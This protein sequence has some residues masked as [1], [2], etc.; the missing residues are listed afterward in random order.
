[1]GVSLPGGGL[2]VKDNRYGQGKMSLDDKDSS[3]LGR[4]VAIHKYQDIG[5]EIP[6]YDKL[7]LNYC[8]ISTAADKDPPNRKCADT[9]GKAKLQDIGIIKENKV[10]PVSFA[11]LDTNTQ[12]VV[13][14]YSTLD[15]NVWYKVKV[16][17]KP[18]R[19]TDDFELQYD[20]AN[21]CARRI[22]ANYLTSSGQDEIQRPDPYGAA[23]PAIAGGI[24]GRM[25][26]NNPK[27]GKTSTG[28][29][30]KTKPPTGV[31]QISCFL[32]ATSDAGDNEIGG[33]AL[34]VQKIG[35]K[36]VKLQAKLKHGTNM[37]G[38]DYSFHFHEFGDLRRLTPANGDNR[39]V[40]KIYKDVLAIDTLKASAGENTRVEETFTLGQNVQSVEEY[41]GRSL[42]IHSGPDTS[43][44]T[45]SYG[46]CG[47]ANPESVQNYDT[48]PP[49]IYVTTPKGNG[50]VALGLSFTSLLAAFL[51]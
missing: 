15:K 48:T 7:C 50:A 4:A 1:M 25:N 51:W 9:S 40:G 12:N 38:K 49:I 20:N 33:E 11:S 46:V 34:I 35:T 17:K 19:Q 41:V 10:T 27:D 31:T 18:T 16:T 14:R 26:P 32:R 3:I 2:V 43:S 5:R 30:D 21:A 24:V 28:N 8:G 29:V 44:P 39:L 45:V 42:T 37:G 23:G 36:E 22:S 47:I 6:L 13:A